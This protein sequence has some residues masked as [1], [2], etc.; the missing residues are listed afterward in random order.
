MIYQDL[1]FEHQ[2]IT[3]G[4]GIGENEGTQGAQKKVISFLRGLQRA[5]SRRTGQTSF[6]KYGTDEYKISNI[7]LQTLIRF[8]SDR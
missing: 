3:A 6:K 8:H 1:I 7:M 2:K 4:D 5:V